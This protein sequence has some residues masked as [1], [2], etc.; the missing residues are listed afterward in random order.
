MASPREPTRQSERTNQTVEIALRYFLT[1]TLATD[2][3]EALPEIQ[4]T[5]NNSLNATTGRSPNEILYGFRV[6]EGL[7][8]LAG[9]PERAN[10][11][12]DEHRHETRD[13]ILSPKR[14]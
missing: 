11:D 12:R 7:Q 5:I 13:A 8:L 6:N 4:A 10:L 1:A 3:S 9:N 14:P 2:W